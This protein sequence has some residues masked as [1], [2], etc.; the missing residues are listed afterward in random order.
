MSLKS[1]V[2]IRIELAGDHTAPRKFDTS[3]RVV[4]EAVDSPQIS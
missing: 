2:I 3:L 4:V 1:E